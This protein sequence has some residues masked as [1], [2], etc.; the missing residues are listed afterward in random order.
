[1]TADTPL[2]SL[3]AVS[4]IDGRYRSKTHGLSE[5]CSEYGLIRYRVKIECEWLLFLSAASGI[6]EL[7]AQPEHESE[8]R[9][10][11]ENFSIR[12]AEAVK[13]TEATTNH[14]VKAVE[15]FVK[16]K[17]TQLPTWAP[18]VEWVHFG[19]TSEDI[20]NVAYALMVKDA[21]QHHLL[22]QMASLIE[23]LDTLANT[24]ANLPMLSRTHGQT[25]SPTTLGKEFKNV[26]ARL[27]RQ[28][29][30]LAAFSPLAKFNGAV[31]NYNAHVSA[32]PELDWMDLG[33]GFINHL[34]L[35]PNLWTTQIEP[36][37]W[38][39]EVAHMLT[40]FNT[41]LLDFN[42]DMWSYISIEYFRQRKVEGETGSS[43]M[44][45]KV[46]P[47]DFENSEGNIG[48]ANALLHHL[49]DKLA[50]SR[51]QRDLSD[52]TVLR[53]LGSAFG[54]CL[55]AYSSSLK[56][57]SRVDVNADRISADLDSSWEVLA[58]PVQTVMRKHG[59]DQPYERLKSATRGN[60]I[61]QAT[62]LDILN[63][64]ELPEAAM[65]EL[66]QLTPQ[67]YIGIAEQLARLPLDTKPNKQ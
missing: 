55:I 32:Y 59:L 67:R 20:N 2:N 39:S 31:G 18:Q 47:I 44:P 52:S 35:E 6:G 51:W 26:A 64:L 63:A 36:H 62:Y 54:H 38:I 48:L 42:R 3:N 28:H 34:G 19:C 5:V 4:A 25:A 13:H 50:V 22:P 8:V 30:T 21:L 46:N 65:Q 16:D 9:A 1:M 56:G 37:D 15:Y 60:T 14:D 29:Q 66:S 45:H 41:I 57:L 49:A 23:E 24:Y 10:I 61:D 33:A 17:L 40:R 27:Y 7:S 12:D 11:Y 43:T 58:E 53:N